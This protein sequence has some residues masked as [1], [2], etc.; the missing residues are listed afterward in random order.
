M[1]GKRLFMGPTPH[2]IIQA[3]EESASRMIRSVA[4]DQLHANSLED[5]VQAVV[6]DKV[7][8]PII[9]DV[10]RHR[11]ANGIMFFLRGR[12]MRVGPRSIA[13]PQPFSDREVI[14]G[15]A[16]HPLHRQP[17]GVRPPAEP[18]AGECRRGFCHEPRSHPVRGGGPEYA[19]S[20][21][22]TTSAHSRAGPLCSGSPK[23]TVTS[24]PWSNTSAAQ[25]TR[26]LSRPPRRDQ[27]ARRHGRRVQHPRTRG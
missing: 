23:S 24:K 4:E 16:V 17:P 26:Q 10:E 9:L 25:A 19:A 3:S 18:H 1:S 20:R 12:A 5:L 14:E 15:F 22:R 2:Q 11:I 6:D 21:G 7:P 13:R 8:Q 27:E